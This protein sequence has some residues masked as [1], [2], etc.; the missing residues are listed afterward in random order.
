M[1]PQVV[2]CQQTKHFV[3]FITRG[4]GL[5]IGCTTKEGYQFDHPH[6]TNNK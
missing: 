4:T 1:S 5:S 3:G 2:W 6:R